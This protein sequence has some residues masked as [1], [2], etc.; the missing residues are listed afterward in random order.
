MMDG[1]IT[2]PRHLVEKAVEMQEQLCACHDEQSCPAVQL[3]KESAAEL[4][5]ALAGQKPSPLPWLTAIDEAMVGAHIGVADPTD[6]YGT[7]KRKLNSLIAWHVQVA[8]DPAV[9]IW[10][11]ALAG[12]TH[13]MNLGGN[14]E[15]DTHD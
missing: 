13:L 12:S 7:A 8:L 9:S 11:R 2:L 5:A 10:D 4:R 15:K 1:S 3:G 14:F 6:D